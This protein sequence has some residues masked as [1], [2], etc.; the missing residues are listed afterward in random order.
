VVNFVHDEILLEVAESDAER[1]AE[2]LKTAMVQAGDWLLGPYGIP[3]EV[4]VAVGRTW[5]KG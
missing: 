1:A 5:P 4:E 2:A 3:T